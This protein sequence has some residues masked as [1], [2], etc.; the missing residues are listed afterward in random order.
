[1]T[2]QK[3]P[4]QA[5]YKQ[6]ITAHILDQDS[7][8]QAIFKGEPNNEA[9][10]WKQVT[11][12]PVILK[13]G[14]HLQFAYF[15]GRQ[16]VSKNYQGEAIEENLARLLDQPGKSIQVESKAEKIRVQFSKKGKAIVHRQ[17]QRADRRPDLTH[18]RRKQYLLPDDKP[19]PFLQAIG[20]M[21]QNGQI[22]AAMQRKFRQI[23]QFL[24]LVMQTDQLEKF[25]HT[26]LNIV[27]FGCGNA[28]LT[29]ALYHYLNHILGIEARLVGVD[30]NPGLIKKQT[31]LVEQL[32]WSNIHFEASP[33]IDFQ[34]ADRP[35][36]VFALH[37]CDTASDEA[38]AQAVFGSSK[39]IFCAPCC[40]HQLQ[41]QLEAGAGPEPLQAVLE[42]N[43][44]RERQGDILTDAF[45][46]TILQL[47]G[48]QTQVIQFIETEHTPKN[49]MIRAVRTDKL[50]TDKP[51]PKRQI[52]QKYQ[53][54]KQFWQV[55]PYLETLLGD[56]LAPPHDFTG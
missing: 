45:R 27:D 54:L 43:I 8:V 40:H 6:L 21:T 53:S 52:W 22:R 4:A 51:L 41:Q 11:I 15:D 50:R 23:N 39:L 5:T 55:T 56:H 7:F 2:K 9:A 3:P 16:T 48:Y 20:I 17:Q 13:K 35:D 44:L 12:R 10:P 32:G 24:Q 46:A 37:A 26:P 18:N 29:F 30:S 14:P 1:M 38:L 25:D 34:P 36:I 28:Y 31:R 42:H 47:L 49:L 33:I 19:D